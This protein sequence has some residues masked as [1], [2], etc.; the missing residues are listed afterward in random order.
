VSG[1]P[2]TRPSAADLARLEE[3][4]LDELMARYPAEWR[5]VGAALVRATAT[6]RPEALEAL[7]REALAAAAPWRER[8]ARSHA[9]PA[10]LAEA[11]PRLAAARLTRLAVERTL[12]AAAAGQASGTVRLGR[13]AGLLV[14][15]LLF[16]RGLDRKPASLT[17]FRLLWPLVPGRRRLMPLVQPRG[18]YCFYSRALVRELARLLSGRGEVL[19]L[20]AGDGTLARFLAAEGLPVRATDDGSWRHAIDYPP[21]VERLGA[22]AALERHRPRAVLCAFPPPGNAFE[23]RVLAAPHV[24]RYLVVTSRHR[25]AAGDWDAYEGQRDFDWRVDERLSR[26]VLPPELDPAVLVFERRAPT[27]GG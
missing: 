19:E 6:G 5:A 25:H 4:P 17:A 18:I 12:L 14:Q 16:R 7:V 24:E 15:A 27:A 13:L 21:E 23:R 10:V 20:G 3:A 2:R 8:V 26:L 22:A 11:L 9:N 1:P